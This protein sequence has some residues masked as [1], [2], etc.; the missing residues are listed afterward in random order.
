MF[1]KPSSVSN[2]VKRPMMWEQ[3]FLTHSGIGEVA[4]GQQSMGLSGGFLEDG[5][6]SGGSGG[7]MLGQSLVCC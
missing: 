6:G 4:S 2:P 7:S 3:P 5:V 1:N